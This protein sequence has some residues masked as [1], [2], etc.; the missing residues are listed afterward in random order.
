MP[1]RHKVQPGTAD[2]LG[3]VWDGHGTNF[4]IFSKNATAVELCLFADDGKTETSRVQLTHKTGDVWHGYVEHL[5]PGQ[6]YSFRVHGPHEPHNGHFFDPQKLS[7]DPYAR[8]IVPGTM[9][10]RVTETDFDWE[11]DQKPYVAPAQSIIY[12]AHVKGLTMTNADIP[13]DLRGTYAGIAHP[14]NIEHL[15]SLGITTLELLPVQ[16][17]MHNEFETAKGLS[18]YWGYNTL[19]FFAPEPSYAAT[20]APITEFKEMVKALHAAGIEVIMDVVYNHTAEGS[21]DHYSLRGIDNASYYRMQDHDKSQNL[22][23]TGCGNTL[24]LTQKCTQD[25]VLESLRYWAEEMHIDG[26]RFDLAT[27]LMFDKNAQ[28]SADSD[29]HKRLFSDPVLSQTKIIAEPWGATNY[30]LG[31]FPPEWSEWNDKFRDEVRSYWH[32]AE[33]HIGKLAARL[34]GSHDVFN[35]KANGPLSGI[36][37][38]TAHDGFTL[39]DVV[40]YNNKHNEANGEDNRDGHSDNH[41]YNYGAEGPTTAPHIHEI[42]HKQM[43]NMLATLFLAQ[44]TPMLLSGDEI[45]NTQNGNNNVYCQD[46]ETGW[47]NWDKTSAAD[48]VQKNFVSKLISLR[49]EFDI[50]GHNEFMHGDKKDAHG[51]K[52]LTWL[53]PDGEE[54]EQADWD[55]AHAKAIAMVLNPSALNATQPRLMAIF[56]SHSGAVDFKLPTL[57][58]SAQNWQRIL[59]TNEPELEAPEHGDS[60]DTTTSHSSGSIYSVPARSVIVFKQEP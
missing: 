53:K 49:N 9:I 25:L 5:K 2:T 39:N 29:F 8:D 7:L 1:A 43:R 50:L 42:R 37:F 19:G 10:A 22:N 12:E 21:H 58:N 30:H 38:L 3:A 33:G 24:D 40:S 41:S 47:L 14:K 26:F 32:G 15:K 17:F 55:D 56:N 45:A 57:N 52:D 11:Q 6:L 59:D 23:A 16:S 48:I 34:A 46:N 31:A 54:Y 51:V 44:G 4:A 18:N 20:D 27:I 28:F 35:H 13:E 36:N 60:N